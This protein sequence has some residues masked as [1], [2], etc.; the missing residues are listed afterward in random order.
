MLLRACGGKSDAL[1]RVD[2][3]VRVELGDEWDA[4]PRYGIKE[5]V[6]FE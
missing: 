2:G 4:Y 3:G 5:V 1:I 6:T